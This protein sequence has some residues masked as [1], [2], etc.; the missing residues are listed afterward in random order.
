MD[1]V[2]E[3][4]M[5]IQM[6]LLGGLGEIHRNCSPDRQVEMVRKV[7]EKMR[8]IAK[9]P[10]R[11]SENETIGDALN[12]LK[13][14]N[15]GYVVV[16]KGSEYKGKICGIATNKDFLAGEITTKIKEVMTST[17]G[18]GGR[19]LVTGEEGMKLDEAVKV[20]IRE[21]IEKLPVLDKKGDLVGVYTL[22]DY[23][24]LK[25]YPKASL[26]ENGRLLVGAAIGV[27][28]IDIERA[29]RLVEAGCDFIFLDI[30]HGHS[31]HTK[32]MVRRLKDREK[33]KTPIVVG[34]FATGDGVRFA[35]DIGADGIKVGIGPGFVCK[36]RSVAGTGVPQISAIL[37]ARQA[38]NGKRNAPPI[39]SDGGIRE[40]GDSGKAIA[41]GA[42]SVMIGSMLAGTKE[43]PGDTVKINGSLQK[44]IRGMASLG[45]L[46]ERKKL[47]DSTTDMTVYAPE[48][49]E[50]FT[51]FKGS[52][53]ELIMEFV[54]GLRS[55][56]SYSGA[57]TIAE[58]QKAKLIHISSNGG[59]EHTRSL[60]R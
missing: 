26:D 2:T 25:D 1:T 44:R 16:Y 14:R 50:T 23:F 59:S 60:G 41:A 6:A 54:G 56:M 12:L 18:R 19:K 52:A 31:I 20:M 27:R 55:S 9:N 37:E 21:R 3:D 57:H 29:L 45:V 58:M 17:E 13:I 8:M 10:P 53:K 22:R 34:N 48:G 32:R 7:K 11:V 49:R 15:R 40:P 39:I 36:T 24:S 47:S 38:L 43:S 35:Y 46:E 30:A 28:E 33:I 42:D 5:A 51:P 4:E